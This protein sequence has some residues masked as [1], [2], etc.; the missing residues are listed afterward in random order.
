MSGTSGQ[1]EEKD[2][3]RAPGLIYATDPAKE[4]VA[5]LGDAKGALKVM[6]GLNEASP[7]LTEQGGENEDSDSDFLDFVLSIPSD[8]LSSMRAAANA[9]LAAAPDKEE[10]QASIFNSAE[11][12]WGEKGVVTRG[13][14]TNEDIANLHLLGKHA[15]KGAN[16]F[17]KHVVAY[18]QQGALIQRNLPH[19]LVKLLA[20]LRRTVEKCEAWGAACW[21][22]SLKMRCVEYHTYTAGTYN[23]SYMYMCLFGVVYLCASCLVL[24]DLV[25]LAC[26]LLVYLAD[27]NVILVRRALGEQVSPRLW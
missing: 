6:N 7:D 13:A 21:H 8:D 1:V 11:L 14:F 20:V 18:M 10:T 24:F 17:A 12:A 3:T 15:N 23:D 19:L 22:S 25:V 4:P 5:L 2:N 27:E 26:Y 16:M 9:S